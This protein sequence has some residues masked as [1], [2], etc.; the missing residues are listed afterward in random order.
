MV[1][2][3]LLLACLALVPLAT[4]EAAPVPPDRIGVEDA[5]PAPVIALVRDLSRIGLP[6]E[7]RILPYPARPV[8]V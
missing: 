8:Q 7:R 3:P 5:R 2:F 6:P 4:L 1:R